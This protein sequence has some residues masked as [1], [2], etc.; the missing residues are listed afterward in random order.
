VAGLMRGDT[1]R[2]ERCRG[3]AHQKGEVSEVEAA[4]KSTHAWQSRGLDRSRR[5]VETK[6]NRQSPHRG[7]PR[8]HEH[9]QSQQGRRPGH[10]HEPARPSQDRAN[11]GV[12]SEARDR[13]QKADTRERSAQERSPGSTPTRQVNMPQ[14]MLRGSRNPDPDRH[15]E[16]GVEDYP[17]HAGHSLQGVG[18]DR[19]GASSEGMTQAEAAESIEGH[20]GEGGGEERSHGAM[21]APRPGYCVANAAA[22][23]ISTCSGS[24]TVTF[25]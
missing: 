8:G 19:A 21:I 11:A 5:D 24:V 7:T 12:T 22:S 20:A 2:G 14:G 16:P 10:G 18:A 13:R 4:A 6:T 17:A 23:E 3:R 1:H 9:N 25:Q 15:V